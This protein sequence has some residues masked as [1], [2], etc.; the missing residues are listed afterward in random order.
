V[1]VG[2]KRAVVKHD[3]LAI[4]TVMSCTLACDHRVLDGAE[5]SQWLQI[6]KKLIEEPA[7]L[8]V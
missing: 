3:Q 7:A 5:G 6:F 8:L 4:A 1:G 2:E